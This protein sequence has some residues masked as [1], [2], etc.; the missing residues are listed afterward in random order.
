MIIGLSG[1]AQSGKDTVANYLVEH[2]GFTRI[3]F[4]DPI[5]EA[6]YNLDPVVTDIPEIS[7]MHLKWLVDGLGWERIKIDSPQVRE[8]LQRFGTEVGRSL[9]GE[10][11]WVDKAMSKV[12]AYDKVV[13]TDVRY[14]NEYDAVKAAGGSMWRVEKPGSVAVNG[15]ASE[16][17][18]DGFFFDSIVMNKGTIED[19]QATISYLISH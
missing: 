8:M 5:R 10:N 16:S 14:P 19:L 18:L 4:A 3:A 9:W 7:G 12:S 6:L 2:H 17:A 1:Y 13:I 11:F 15:H